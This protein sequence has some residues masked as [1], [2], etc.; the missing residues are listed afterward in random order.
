M[1]IASRRNVITQVFWQK[2]HTCRKRQTYLNGATNKLSC[3]WILQIIGLSVA[4]V[5]LVEP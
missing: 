3:G 2:T 5:W 1:T 4:I